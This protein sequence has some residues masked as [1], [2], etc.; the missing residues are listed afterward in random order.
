MELGLYSA[1]IKSSDFFFFKKQEGQ[2]LTGYV[3]LGNIDLCLCFDVCIAF[4]VS[5]IIS[6]LFKNSVPFIPLPY[7]F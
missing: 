4:V 6:S 3:I 2:A 5:R 1:T 7:Q